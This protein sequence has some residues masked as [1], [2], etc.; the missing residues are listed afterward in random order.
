MPLMRRR[1]TSRQ[2]L[3]TN[4]RTDLGLIGIISMKNLITLSKNTN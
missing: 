1:D 2:R 3:R 4:A